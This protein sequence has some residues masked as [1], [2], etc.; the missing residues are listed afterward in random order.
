MIPVYGF[1]EGD[2]IGLLI[3]ADEQELLA[4]TAAK[5]QVA[6]RL[7]AALDGPLALFINGRAVEP[8]TTVQQAGLK[9]LDRLDVRRGGAR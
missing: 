2:T 6:A 1:L 5:V 3:L 7:R 4:V 8:E 9:A